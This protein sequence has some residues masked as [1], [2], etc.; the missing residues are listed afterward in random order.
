VGMGGVGQ[1]PPVVISNSWTHESPWE[2]TGDTQKYWGRG[3][4]TKGW[5]QVKTRSGNP[6]INSYIELS[7]ITGARLPLSW[8]VILLMCC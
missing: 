5:G 2:N 1:T 8:S 4:F 3:D 7:C 6:A